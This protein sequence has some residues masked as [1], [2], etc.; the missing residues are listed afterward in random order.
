MT[1]AERREL[2]SQVRARRVE[3]DM[4]QTDLA[5]A[6]GVARQTISNLENGMAP[7]ESNL[8]AILS[9]LGISATSGNYSP[10]TEMWLGLIGGALEALPS[11]RRGIAGQSA[12]NAITDE[13]RDLSSDVAGKADDFGLAARAT[14]PE[15]TDET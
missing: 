14:D 5:K 2:A 12:M 1:A 4:T 15:P 9:V 7:Q 6:A 11:A 13:L 8:R 3:L 10:D